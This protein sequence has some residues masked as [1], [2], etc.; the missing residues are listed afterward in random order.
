MD[1]V[2]LPKKALGAKKGEY[3][4]LL[5]INLLKFLWEFLSSYVHEMNQE[6]TLWNIKQQV[7]NNHTVYSKA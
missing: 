5:H 2:M 3:L 4:Q 6:I 7:R 1:Q